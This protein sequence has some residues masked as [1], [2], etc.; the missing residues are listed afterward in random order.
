MDRKVE[1]IPYQDDEQTKF[2]LV[3]T[4]P[5]TVKTIDLGTQE[6][7]GRKL[8][9]LDIRNIVSESV[10]FGAGFYL[11]SNGWERYL[12]GLAEQDFGK[13]IGGAI[14]GV[15]GIWTFIRGSDVLGKRT[16]ALHSAKRHWVR[17]K[18]KLPQFV[19]GRH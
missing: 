8:L 15:V 9:W 10:A 7:T 19:L 4:E 18:Q 14:E 2:S 3:I 16:L 13:S 17:E 12:A 6:E 5:E 11:A 1:V